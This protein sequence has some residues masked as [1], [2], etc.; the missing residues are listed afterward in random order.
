MSLGTRLILA[1]ALTVG[2]TSCAP[3]PQS[4]PGPIAIHDTQHPS[5]LLSN[6]II[7]A[8]CY[9]PDAARGFYRGPRFDWSGMVGPVIDGKTW[10]FAPF[11]VPQDPLGND[12]GVGPAEEFGMDSPLGYADARPGET[13]I[14]I[15]V[16]ELI[17]PNDPAYR[18]YGFYKRFTIARAGRWTITYGTDWVEFHQSLQDSRGWGYDYVKRISL[19][20]DAPVLIIEHRLTNTGSKIIDTTWYCHNFTNID[21]QPI[22]PAYAVRFPV[23]PSFDPGPKP[24]E[25][26][27][28]GNWLEFIRPIPHA[29]GISAYL[30]NAGH[31]VSSD[32]A[33]VVNR[34]IG[35]GVKI[36]GDQPVVK[37][38]FYAEATA[39]CPEMFIRIRIAPGESKTWEAR[40]QFATRIGR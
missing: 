8:H 33:A 32:S 38:H 16:G 5:V 13:F 31:S 6:G 7:S 3:P 1:A 23:K 17:K 28:K 19:A 12:D 29:Y 22:G 14:K 9:L 10:F 36:T 30:A 24:T 11:R 18:V 25:A 15:G 35:A 37:Y 21:G 2:V 27:T 4:S 26:R 34:D 20:K 40:Y 39:A